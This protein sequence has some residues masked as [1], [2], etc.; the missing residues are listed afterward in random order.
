[1]NVSTY[2]KYIFFTTNCLI[3]GINS[4]PLVLPGFLGGF[5]A[6]L[7]T[8]YLESALPKII[9]SISRSSMGVS[10]LLNVYLVVLIII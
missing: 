1:M 10:V 6:G 5:H 3:Y 4:T 2:G 7:P 8:R 9:G